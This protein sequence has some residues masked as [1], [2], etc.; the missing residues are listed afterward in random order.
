MSASAKAIWPIPNAVPRLTAPNSSAMR[1]PAANAATR[2]VSC[3]A[4]RTQELYGSTV[5]HRHR[6]AMAIDQSGTKKP[7]RREPAM[8]LSCIAAAFL[9]LEQ[10]QNGL[11]QLVR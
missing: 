5:V 3:F 11:R 7:H 10:G 6:Y 9:A 2:I 1:T 8:G 4:S